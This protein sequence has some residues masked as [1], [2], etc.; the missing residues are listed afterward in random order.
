MLL[1]CIF[2]QFFVPWVDVNRGWGGGGP[3]FQCRIDVKRG[4][5]SLDGSPKQTW[6][7]KVALE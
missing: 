3:N 7:Y 1:S 2:K 4:T 6:H 5:M